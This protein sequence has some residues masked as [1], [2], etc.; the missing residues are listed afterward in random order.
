MAVGSFASLTAPHV[1]HAFFS[2][3]FSLC[4]FTTY[5]CTSVPVSSGY[6]GFGSPASNSTVVSSSI[7]F[8]SNIIGFISRNLVESFLY[9]C[10]TWIMFLLAFQTMECL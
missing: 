9:V 7:L 4:M 1:T 8:A 5:H 3:L 6:L 2:V 10:L